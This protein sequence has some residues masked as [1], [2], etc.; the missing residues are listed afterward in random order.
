M[1]TIT[2]NVDDK[3]VKDLLKAIII[4]RTD[5]SFGGVIDEFTMEIANALDK[6][7]KVKNINY[8]KSILNFIG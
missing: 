1:K 2:L 3:V 4:K 7:V 8:R 6:K 5:G